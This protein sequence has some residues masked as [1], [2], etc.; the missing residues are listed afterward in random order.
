MRLK[1]AIFLFLL[2]FVAL[3]DDWTV[4]GS[5]TDTTPTGPEYSPVYHAECRVNAVEVY[6]NV[7]L[8]SPLF[9]TVL[10]YLP[11]D[12]LDCRV[13]NV[14]TLGDV[15]GPWSAWVEGIRAVTPDATSNFILIQVH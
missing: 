11:T 6:S 8:A 5:W 13:K 3:A 10:T 2:P 7:N 4:T 12:V 1:T 15:H 14:N 9:T